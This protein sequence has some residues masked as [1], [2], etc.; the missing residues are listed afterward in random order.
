MKHENGGLGYCACGNQSCPDLDVIQSMKNEADP[1]PKD[2]ALA[3]FHRAVGEG[4][5]SGGYVPKKPAE[6]DDWILYSNILQSRAGGAVQR[7]HTIR[8]Q[9]SYSVAEHSWGAAM[10]LWYLYPSEA[11]RLVFFILAHDVPEGLTGDV[12]S[13]AKG[14]DDGLDHHINREFG[15]PAMAD[16]GEREHHILKSVDQLE[17]YMWGKEQVAQGNLYANEIIRNLDA[18]FRDPARNALEKT[19]MAFYMK[20]LFNVAEGIIPNRFQLLKSIKES[21]GY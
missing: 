11:K 2:V 3:Q 16:V 1:S 12:P 6:H 21:H 15:L 17:L 19:A 10:L 9:G 13:T 8:H 14:T 7:C 20:R 5:R 18:T 4:F